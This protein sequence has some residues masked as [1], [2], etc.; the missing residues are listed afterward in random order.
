MPHRAWRNSSERLAIALALALA[1]TLAAPAAASG[2]QTYNWVGACDQTPHDWVCSDCANA[3]WSPSGQPGPTDTAHI[4]V[5]AVLARGCDKSVSVL[6]VTDGGFLTIR[7][8]L[9]VGTSASVEGV[10]FGD[11]ATFSSTISTA[12]P[13]VMNGM[14]NSW[15]RGILTGAGRFVVAPGAMLNI[16]PSTTE[17]S[18]DG[19]RLV[20][21]GRIN[22][23]S[24][25]NL[26]S[27]ATIENNGTWTMAG[28]NLGGSTA[29][30]RNGRFDNHGTLECVG[31]GND[32]YTV[33]P[34]ESDGTIR[35][36]GRVLVVAA[37][38]AHGGGRYEVMDGGTIVLAGFEV[39]G[40]ARGV[41]VAGAVD[42]TGQ[43]NLKLEQETTFIDAGGSLN[44]TLE[45]IEG[46]PAVV[47]LW[48]ENC[49]VVQCDGELVNRGAMR[50]SRGTFTG[51]TGVT[52]QTAG[53][54]LIDD[55][56]G[57][58]C[59]NRRLET[60]L[61]SF[62]TTEQHNDVVLGDGG[63]IIAGGE[64]R[65]IAGNVVDGGGDNL[66]RTIL[67]LRR[68]G[69]S[70][71]AAASIGV[72]YEQTISG[73]II[74]ETG[75]LFL[76]GGG[77][78]A[79]GVWSILP[80]GEVSIEGGTMTFAPIGGGPGGGLVEIS[81]DGTFRIAGAATVVDVA[82]DTSVHVVMAPSLDER[83]FEFIDGTIAG[84]GSVLNLGDMNWR[85]GTI[86]MERFTNWGS[87]DLPTSG[88]RTLRG[89]LLNTLGT[90]SGGSLTI[91]G[92]ALV[93][94][95][96]LLLFSGTFS[97]PNGGVVD[98]TGGVLIKEGTAAF[99][100]SARFIAR[101]GRVTVAS[102]TL[103]LT[104]PIDELVDGT[105]TGGRWGVARDA[106][107]NIP[108]AHV[109]R[110]S[111]PTHVVLEG[112]ASF[113]AIDSIVENF[114]TV[115]VVGDGD[116]S[117]PDLRLNDRAIRV[118]GG[119]TL[120]TN[121][122][123]TNGALGVL[124]QRPPLAG[125]GD[126]GGFAIPTLVNEGTLRPGG[127]DATG[128]F[129][130]TGDLVQAG[131]GVIDVDLAGGA[132]VDEHDQ[133]QVDGDVT[134]AG[135]LHVRVLP[136]YA[137]VGGET[138]TVLTVANGTIAG[139]FDVIDGAGAYDASYTATTVVLTL[140]EPPVPGDVD[141]DGVVGFG[142]LL[143]VLSAWGDCPESK[144]CPADLDGD[145]D[146]DFADLLIVLSAWT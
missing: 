138:F 101:D 132:P 144:P 119:G 47:G 115:E 99:A 61:T 90:I 64:Y 134:L 85:G 66:F 60:T 4:A 86:T 98:N 51:A 29:P 146:V 35:A 8:N 137:P 122:S 3:N 26:E 44:A 24:A 130:L 10:G 141:G 49:A 32:L 84:A 93:N 112:G 59:G 55:V 71:T 120:R 116:R 125:P 33:I 73:G 118:F 27:A 91:D 127:P 37:G 102:G 142:D 140:V 14:V 43:G 30:H 69:A 54:L 9:S 40:E 45:T 104:G 89:T 121:G 48:I 46:N 96:T 79:G 81:G 18:L 94:E 131:S 82:V 77:T 113:P 63:R 78:V 57:S 38:G 67:M 110:L 74:A 31:A 42:A 62:G 56:G 11:G 16:S 52:N 36:V 126:P 5:A 133:V 109:T 7:S 12:G 17:K 97:G 124:E 114:A 123:V 135:T 106:T 92:G 128:A 2:P 22:S 50:W 95:R 103:D 53:T 65:M 88:S 20:N 70:P 23:T 145:R 34:V 25:F 15:S 80:D 72:P 111:T 21:D 143:A 87:I 139:A 136:G 39:D 28:D 19:T 117:L 76:S 1:P 6:E 107:L 108:G 83:E 105:L 58:G 41:H 100:I 13:F 68:Q 129:V 75:K